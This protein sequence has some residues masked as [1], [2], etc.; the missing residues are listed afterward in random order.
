MKE[1]QCTKCHEVKPET[2]EYFHRNGE[3]FKNQ[4]KVCRCEHSNAYRLAN[5]DE[6]NRKQNAYAAEHRGKNSVYAKAWRESPKGQWLKYVNRLKK[7]FG[8]NEEFIR[9]MMDTQRGCC[10]ICGLSLV[11]KDSKKNHAVDHNHDTGEVRGLL[12]GDCN[13]VLGNAKDSPDNLMRAATYL[14]SRGYYG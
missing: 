13:L 9:D 10:A 1:K 11:D 2:A 7:Y 12:C 3:G 8:T 14:L 4:C 6:I 5:K